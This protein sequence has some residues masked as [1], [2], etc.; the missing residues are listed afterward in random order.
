MKTCQRNGSFRLSS[1]MIVIISRNGGTFAE[2][3]ESESDVSVSNTITP[4]NLSF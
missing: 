3:S 1:L 2:I 4:F